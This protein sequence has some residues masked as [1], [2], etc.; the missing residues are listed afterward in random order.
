MLEE[1]LSR[2]LVLLADQVRLSCALLYYVTWIFTSICIILH[3]CLLNIFI[4]C[5]SRI[6]IEHL[7][8]LLTSI[9][10]HIL[11][12]RHSD[13]QLYF[14]YGCITNYPDL[15][16]Q[17]FVSCSFC[18]VGLQAWLSQMDLSCRYSQPGPWSPEGLTGLGGSTSKMAH[19]HSWQLAGGLSSPLCG[20]YYKSARA[21]L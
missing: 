18:M 14:I 21:A 12:T 19:S 11:C 13:G 3:S 16:Q 9:Y 7:T 5:P 2:H 1:F 4:M 10:W 20:P 15:K 17:T 8:Y 6:F